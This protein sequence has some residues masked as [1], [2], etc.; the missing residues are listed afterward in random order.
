[1][2]F[3]SSDSLVNQMLCHSKTDSEIPK[4]EEVERQVETQLKGQGLLSQGQAQSRQTPKIVFVVHLLGH[5]TIFQYD[6]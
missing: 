3:D 5:N 2:C 6:L 1:M 4:D